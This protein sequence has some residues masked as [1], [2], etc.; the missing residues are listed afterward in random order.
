MLHRYRAVETE[1]NVLSVARSFLVASELFE[2][3]ELGEQ[4]SIGDG[5]VDLI[6][7]SHI[8]EFKRRLGLGNEIRD[9]FV[10]Q[11]DGYLESAKTDAPQIRFGVLTDGRSW[12]LR[13]PD[14]SYPTPRPEDVFRLESAEKWFLLYE[15][16]APQVSRSAEP[17][18]P[19]A[20]NIAARLGS[21]SETYRIAMDQ[22]QELRNRAANPDS[23]EV[24]KELWQDLLAAAL[25]E[26][27]QVADSEDLF[28]RHTYLSAAVGIAIHATFDLDVS[29]I[30]ENE[31]S[32]L[33]SGNRFFL[34]TGIHG[35]VNQGFFSWPNEVDGF[36]DWLE[37]I[38]DAVNQF[39]WSGLDLDFA[40]LL[41]ESIISPDERRDLGE[42]YTPQWLADAVVAE[43]V[44]D[45]LHQSVLD[46]ACGSGTFLWSALRRY[47]AAGREADLPA[48][49]MLDWALNNIIGMDVHPVAVL[50]AR[51]TWL[52][53]VR[54]LLEATDWQ[55]GTAV[56]VYLGDSLQL[57]TG[58]RRDQMFGDS[59]VVPI[60]AGDE[61]DAR[62][63]RFP[64]ALVDQ[65]DWFD[66]VMHSLAREIQSDGDPEAWL[67]SDPVLKGEPDLAHTAL[68]LSELHKEGRNHIWAYYT[69]NLVRPIALSRRKV[70]IIVGNPPWINY[71]Q[72]DGVIR[73]RMKE[74]SRGYGIWS[75]GHYA[76]HQDIA[77]LF[78]ARCAHLYL[79]DGG[80][81]GFVLPHSALQTGQWAAWRGGDWADSASGRAIQMDMDWKL[82][83]DLEGLE[84]N[85][86]F[87]VAS[88]VVF[89]RSGSSA[90]F[91]SAAERWQGPAGG[92]VSR[93]GR[94]KLYDTSGAMASPYGA[95]ARNGATLFPRCLL[96]VEPG[97]SRSKIRP[98]DTQVTRPRRGRFDKKP[99]KDLHLSHFHNMTVESDHIFDVHLGETLV[100]YATLE[101]L[102][103]ILPARKASL[104][105]PT[106]GDSPGGVDPFSMGVRVR[107]RWRSMAEFW[108]ANKKPNDDKSLVEQI[109][110][111]G[112][113]TAQFDW[114][115]SGD[116]QI[117][118]A[119]AGSGRPTAAVLTDP[120]EIA[121]YTLFWIACNSIDEANFLSAVINSETLERSVIPLAVPNWSGKVRHLQKH[122]WRL[123]IPNFDPSSRLHRDIASAGVQAS[124]GVDKVLADLRVSRDKV[125]VTI[126]RREVR[127]WLA[128]SKEGN[129]V[130]SLVE[131]LLD[132]TS[133]C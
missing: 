47:I 94:R 42:Y 44:T 100:P 58:Y 18:K 27:G 30:V 120:S 19:T 81:M 53:A 50:L 127:D 99:W 12:V 72:T 40:R 125:T 9:E 119:Y 63:L 132:S 48:E 29:G 133:D 64:V 31:P 113:L 109:D 93:E 20:T 85:D 25:G 101:P 82:P 74:L 66:A 57:R 88:C 70:D 131:R 52:F 15:W 106:R 107:N 130:E 76:T 24:K 117:R 38:A 83:W 110:Y 61:S 37:A 56:P 105:I 26:A 11:L 8:F 128:N 39:D 7:G 115:R 108:D 28:L 90:R 49:R 33:L 62:E 32:E 65:S 84:P 121:D 122:L 86:F 41:Y 112:K 114:M 111:F 87:P 35:A 124:N 13:W 91:A 77:G 54:E 22:L 73:D 55:Q 79:N 16:L 102:Q 126:A 116:G 68:Q 17:L 21:G 89:G 36:E 118:I 10:R 92:E 129:V 4:I 14:Q 60:R 51:A 6:G 34:D 3:K 67:E 59:A 95:K 45:P 2:S 98:A 103:V 75:G 23:I 43:V 1:Q 104:R 97:Q 96:F 80:Q 71:N 123:P 78:Y 5:L 69:R 46:P